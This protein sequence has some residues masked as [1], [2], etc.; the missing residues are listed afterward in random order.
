MTDAPVPE[1]RAE[2][3]SA[4]EPRESVTP[5]WITPRT[6]AIIAF[7][8]LVLLIL[9]M[10]AAPGV[11]QT[12]LLGALLGLALSFPVRLLSRIMPRKLAIP[13]VLVLLLV[14]TV[15][16]AGALAVQVDDLVG[17]LPGMADGASTRTSRILD[18]LER[19]DMLPIPAS[20]VMPQLRVEIFSNAQ[21]MATIAVNQAFS[22]V[23]GAVGVL[24]QVFAMVFIASYL[25]IDGARIRHALVTLVPDQYE[26]EVHE[27][28][29]EMKQVLD[30]YLGGQ[31]LSMT[32]QGAAAAI[33]LSFLDIPYA[34]LIGVWTAATAILPFIGAFLGA[35]PAIVLAFGI[36]PWM[37][38]GV[39]GFYLVMNQIEGNLL[40]PRIQGD[41]VGVHPLLIFLGILFGGSVFG[42]IG[43]IAAVPALAVCRVLVL[44]L[45]KRLRVYGRAPVGP[46]PRP[47]AVVYDDPGAP[48]ATA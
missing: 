12:I 6:E 34:L 46:A 18:E 23:G 14:S 40:T 36:S 33:V 11:F 31:L 9:A 35:V 45:A 28:S 38:L 25:L 19:R 27:L 30:R 4:P 21:R 1:A 15:L 42:F 44:F 29:R 2:I 48:A 5:I 22:V 32:I 43:A 39:A 3:V 13:I 47:S 37:A 7:C 10:R 20:E 8:A 41:A 16:L 17:A 24:L 26:P